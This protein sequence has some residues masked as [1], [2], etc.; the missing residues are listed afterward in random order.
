MLVKTLRIIADIITIK[1]KAKDKIYFPNF[2]VSQKE[3]LIWTKRIFTKKVCKIC[4]LAE[5]KKTLVIL[6]AIKI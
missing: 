3:S 6:T 5:I 1:F 4:Y 2:L